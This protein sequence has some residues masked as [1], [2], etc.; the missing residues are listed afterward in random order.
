[1]F[2]DFNGKIAVS[3]FSDGTT[4]IAVF[5]SDE[6]SILTCFLRKDMYS[7]HPMKSAILVFFQTD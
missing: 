2:P 5:L 3:H 7:H 6:F 4:Q 1:M